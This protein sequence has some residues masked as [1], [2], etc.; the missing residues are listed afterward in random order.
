MAFRE[1]PMH[2]VKEV[3]RLWLAGQS[4]RSI[5]D[6]TAVDRKTVRRYVA[7]GVDAG[8]ARD[9]GETQLTDELLGVV[10]ERVRPVRTNGRGG[11]RRLLEAHTDEITAWLETD[12]LTVKKVHSL[13]CRKG[14]LV[15]ARTLER[16]CAELCGPRRGRTTTV[17]LADGAPGTE[18]QCD[19]GRM[20]GRL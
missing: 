4:L 8:L 6:K 9:G 20:G 2:E 17:R 12:G 13:L 16:F 18:L 5:A 19:F 11:A 3:L 1:V 10:A 14:V 15:P 7:G